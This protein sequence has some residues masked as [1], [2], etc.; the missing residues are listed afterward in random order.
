MTMRFRA[1][2]WDAIDAVG[3]DA[4]SWLAGIVTCDLPAKKT[5]GARWGL[6]LTKQGKVQAELLLTR[7]SE[8]ALAIAVRGGD[9]QV[10]RDVLE[11]HLVME[12]VELGPVR[13]VAHAILLGVVAAHLPALAARGLELCSFPAPF[14]DE[15]SA[16]VRWAGD[17]PGL[18]FAL[19]E[20]GV[21]LS[22]RAWDEA[23][24]ELGLPTFGEDYD[25]ADNPHQAS[26]ERRAVSWQKGCYL[27]QEVVFMQDARG[28]VKR[29]L[30]RLGWSREAQL[31]P[32]ARVT[33]LAGEDVG[34]LTTVGVGQ[35]LARLNAPHFEDGTSLLVGQQLVVVAALDAG[36]FGRAG[37]AGRV[38]K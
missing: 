20:V 34:Q 18:V 35:G 33:T 32:G 7:E 26:L 22:A 36:H 6:L 4:P 37:P 23:R 11:H 2:S 27:G 10:V 21:E 29:R 16:L 25:L 14:G 28:K 30:A 5:D 1:F 3:V 8:A 13:P 12:D 24:V 19:S 31:V 38:Q 15:S 17:L 9:A